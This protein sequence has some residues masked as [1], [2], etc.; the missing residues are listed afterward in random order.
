MELISLTETIK[1][2]PTDSPLR[3]VA[4]QK[5]WR[6]LTQ[7]ENQKLI[8]EQ[9]N[10]E[11]FH[12]LK[13]ILQSGTEPLNA[14]HYSANCLWYL[15]RYKPNK[16][17]LSSDS[18]DI[19]PILIR[20]LYEGE[21]ELKIP[22]IT[23]LNNIS[24][25][26][27]S[28]S[29]LLRSANHHYSYLEYL[30]RQIQRCPG[31]FDSFRALSSLVSTTALHYRHD[32]SSSSLQLIQDIINLNIHEIVLQR[33][34]AFGVQCNTWP[35]IYTDD[36]SVCYW[37]L[38]FLMSFSSLSLG[39][40]AIAQLRN[41]QSYYLFFKQLLSCHT[42]DSLKAMIV[43]ANVYGGGRNQGSLI[44]SKRLFSEKERGLLED[45][46]ELFPML[47][48]TL[49]L[50]YHYDEAMQ[51]NTMGFRFQF[52]YGVI[53]IRDLA[54]SLKNLSLNDSN[55]RIM[56]TSSQKHTKQ[57]FRLIATGL[58]SFVENK[59]EFSYNDKVAE[60]FA[61]GGGEDHETFELFLELLLQLSYS[62]TPGDDDNRFW[63]YLREFKIDQMLLRLQNH[64]TNHV[65]SNQE[66]KL[67][68]LLLDSEGEHGNK[69]APSSSFKSSVS[70]LSFL[71]S[72]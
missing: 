8:G 14:K 28:H 59:K 56:M 50:T 6:M 60:S 18:L 37:C 70:F 69:L 45:D 62:V 44:P 38:N 9:Q 5:V 39:G 66:H 61:G 68:S 34:M 67:I 29:S 21:E 48:N 32:S 47:L 52:Y 71:L 23:A 22:I 16:Y 20:V 10:H 58:A 3:Y 42:M 64:K 15:S 72:R 4:F 27:E 17:V 11:F 2:T 36:G 19:I 40:E 46:Y 12:L 63:T 1:N 30:K 51:N 31:E 65:L 49:D 43:Y 41:S 24:L 33:L 25:V 7:E 35:D 57:L 13:D 26:K 55:K 54:S 53:G